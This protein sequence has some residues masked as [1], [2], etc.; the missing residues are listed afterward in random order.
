LEAVSFLT[1]AAVLAGHNPI[2][3][4]HEVRRITPAQPII[5]AYRRFDRDIAQLLKIC[6]SRKAGDGD[7]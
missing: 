1:D 7:G 2:E 4:D 3:M 6:F 5:A